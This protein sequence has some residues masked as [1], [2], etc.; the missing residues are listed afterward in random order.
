[1]D[2]KVFEQVTCL[3]NCWDEPVEPELAQSRNVFTAEPTYFNETQPPS[4]LNKSSPAIVCFYINNRGQLM[5]MMTE[6]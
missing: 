4:P 2:G 3:R 6:E 1:M 5:S